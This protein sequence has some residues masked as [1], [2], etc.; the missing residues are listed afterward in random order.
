MPYPHCGPKVPSVW[1][2]AMT[3]QVARSQSPQWPVTCWPRRLVLVEHQGLAYPALAQA[4]YTWPEQ[5][6]SA[7]T[8][9]H[10]SELC[11]LVSE[12]KHTL[13]PGLSSTGR[14]EVVKHE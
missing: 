2:Q 1:G 3:G 4:V 6:S 9:Y 14:G 7:K 10:Y 5:E 8:C 13:G 11:T 12:G